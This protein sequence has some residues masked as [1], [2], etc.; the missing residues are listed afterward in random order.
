[1]QS[2]V[3]FC[4]FLATTFAE[5][6]GIMRDMSSMEIV[7]EML[8]GW[9]LGNTLDSWDDKGNGDSGIEIETSWGNPKTTKEMFD[10]VKARGFKTIRIPVTWRGHFGNSPDYI[11]DSEWLDRVEEVVN[12]AL[13][14]KTYV[15]INSHHDEW[16][17]LTEA[18]KTEVADKISRIW[19]QIAERFKDYSDYLLFE[20]LNEPRLYGEPEEWM[21]GTASARS[22]LNEY[23]HAIVSAIRTT[24]GNNALRHI[25]IPTHAAA[26]Y[27]ETQDALVIPEN[28]TRIIV[29]QHIYFPYYFT[30]DTSPQTSTDQWGSA[31]D[32]EAMIGEFDRL[33]EKFI[34]KGIPVV[35]GEWG[36]K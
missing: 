2:L 21:G 4:F 9:N 22:I 6:S 24:G 30:M 3:V 11:I 14:G 23:N 16:V 35:I 13:D 32:K 20:T 29:S 7:R 34:S 26:S 1:M 31:A 27:A 25:L 5:S 12:Y 18:T 17:T 8:V 10:T 19:T 15:I 33:E 28:D 36:S